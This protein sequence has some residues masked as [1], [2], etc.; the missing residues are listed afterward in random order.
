MKM[1]CFS[2]L[3]SPATYS[4]QNGH[5]YSLGTRT[6]QREGISIHSH[7]ISDNLRIFMLIFHEHFPARQVGWPPC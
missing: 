5:E 2:F 6:E 3:R 7:N 4:E 1:C